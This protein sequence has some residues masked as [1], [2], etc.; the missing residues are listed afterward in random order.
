MVTR[1]VVLAAAF[2]LAFCFV[3]YQP[4]QIHLSYGDNLSELIVTWS[5]LNKTR[6][7]VVEY[8]V[9]EKRGANKFNE[10]AEGKT[11]VFTTHGFKKFKNKIKTQYVHSV[12]LTGLK[13][14]KSYLYHVGS[15]LGWSE[16]F[17]FETPPADQ[18]SWSPHVVVF[19]DMGNENPQSLP[20]LQQEVQKG[21]YDAILHIGDFAYDLDSDLGERGDQFMRQ[22][23]SVAAYVP[24]MTCMGNHEER[25]NYSEYRN[26]F[27][28]PGGEEGEF[29]YSFNLG[30]VHFISISTE[31]YYFTGYGLKLVVK[32]FNWLEKDLEEANLEKN[33]RL[34]PWI[35]VVGHRPMYCSNKK[36]R[37][38]S[39]QTARTRT[40]LP[41]GNWF[42]LEN[43][44]FKHRVD[45]AFWAHQHSYERLWPIYNYTVLNGSTEAPYTNPRA[46]VHITTGS[47]GCKEK[48]SPFP[49]DK[50][51]WSAFRSTDY[52]YTRLQP[53]NHTHLFVSQV[54]DTKG[55][56]IIDSIWIIKEKNKLH[57]SP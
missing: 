45:L 29:Y 32:Q 27:R 51:S 19:G 21:M 1:L 53:A 35:V 55:G 6:T 4:E 52:G 2:G 43:L 20:R 41:V 10:R 7:P 24:Y 47:A 25:H 12:K 39:D 31:V 3:G 56:A 50:P 28:M 36:H 13:P 37:D 17:F 18:S 48:T 34:R 22:I 11:V 33:R 49:D 14:G 54:S 57:F 30:P 15:E 8:A 23:Q 5:T 42:G 38:C 44:L 26:R 40:G 46:P 16:V 9:Q